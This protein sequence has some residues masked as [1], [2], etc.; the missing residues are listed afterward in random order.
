MS[1]LPLLPGYVF[2]R[3]NAQERLTALRSDFVVR[4]LEVSDQDLLT[5]ELSQIRALKEAGASLVRLPEMAPGEA[6]QIT[7]GPFSG[8]V[9]VV[10]RRQGRSRLVVSVSMVRQSVGVEFPREV[11]AP[12]V[13][14]AS[15]E[16][17][18]DA[19]RG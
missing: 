14:R 5:Q 13:Q 7:E 1:H 12:I 2:F 19:A 6:V 11:L 16:Q 3:G 8:Y 9:G 17:S 15:L 18:Q 10:L 4:V